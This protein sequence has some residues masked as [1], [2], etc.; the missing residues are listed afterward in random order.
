MRSSDDS[1]I[2]R[3]L[4]RS[5]STF[6]GSNSPLADVSTVD[7]RLQA[8]SMLLNKAVI[9]IG[10]P[11]P[12]NADFTLVAVDDK[13]GFAS[14]SELS[15][16][17]RPLPTTNMRFLTALMWDGRE[18]NPLEG[19]VA[20]AELPPLGV[21]ADE[22]ANHDQNLLADFL[23][24]SNTATLT[25]A[26]AVA[27]GLTADQEAGITAFALNLATAQ[28]NSQRGGGV[29]TPRGAGGP[30]PMLNSPFFVSINDSGD[31]SL[32]I[33]GNGF[34]RRAFTLFDAWN[35]VGNPQR[36]S[37]ARGQEIFNTLA[38]NAGGTTCTTCHGVPN[39]GTR[40][41]NK[42]SITRSPTTKSLRRPAALHIPG[43]TGPAR[44]SV[45]RSGIG[46]VNR[47]VR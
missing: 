2:P 41:L 31:P 28:R 12:V 9:R 40:S 10:R 27:P 15:L 18:S 7:A 39:V 1:R 17:R 14:A 44:S 30:E 33:T 29:S 45:H 8:Y 23:H 42:R 25:H 43:N 22:A 4:I 21:I 13:F 26:Q 11:M 5:F 20:V 16:F 32:D 35:K 36:K 24:Q 47:Q 37:I 6:D 19:R 38:L 34:N 3:G 46:P